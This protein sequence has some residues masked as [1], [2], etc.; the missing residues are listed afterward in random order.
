MKRHTCSL[1]TI[2]LNTH[3]KRSIFLFHWKD[4]LILAIV[5]YCRCL[6]LDTHKY[7]WNMRTASSYWRS[8]DCTQYVV[9]FLNTSSIISNFI[10]AE[11]FS[12]LMGIVWTWIFFFDG[13]W[14]ESRLWW[15][16]IRQWKLRFFFW[17]TK[18]VE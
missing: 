1:I 12:F 2:F 4:D 17:M 11:N 6:Y 8:K 3:V 7:M 14:W 18:F 9:R 5:R 15:R 10:N 13:V 16:F